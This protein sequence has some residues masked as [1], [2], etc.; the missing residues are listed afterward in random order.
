MH[1]SHY[2]CRNSRLRKRRETNISDTI[3]KT[4]CHWTCS[5]TKACYFIGTFGKKYFSNLMEWM[6]PKNRNTE[7]LKMYAII[8]C[9]WLCKWFSTV[10]FMPRSIEITTGITLNYCKC[11][12]IKITVVL[13]TMK[14][15]SK[16]V[17]WFDSI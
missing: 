10:S 16:L 5:Q 12:V 14:V 2:W 9:P 3:S 15:S 11:F 7:K 1:E 17:S 6:M 4:W 8:K 13:R